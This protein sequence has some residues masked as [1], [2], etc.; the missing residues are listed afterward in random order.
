[1]TKIDLCDMKET[2]KWMKY[3]ENLGYKVIGID[4]YISKILFDPDE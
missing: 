4:L 2:T 3:Y 1:M